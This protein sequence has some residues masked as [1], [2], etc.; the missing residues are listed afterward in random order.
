MEPQEKTKITWATLNFLAD[1]LRNKEGEIDLRDVIDIWG[2][3]ALKIVEEAMIMNG[4]EC[5]EHFEFFMRVTFNDAM[6][7]V[8][9]IGNTP[10]SKQQ[11]KGE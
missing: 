4:R 2:G 6:K 8:E 10:E 9:K 1:K 7:R 11:T 5:K 3:M